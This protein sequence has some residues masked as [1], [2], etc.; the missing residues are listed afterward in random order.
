MAC[1]NIVKKNNI[2]FI[3]QYNLFII[4]LCRFSLEKDI[5]NDM[6]WIRKDDAGIFF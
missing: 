2:H 1:S 3:Q 6:I 5:S 4:D